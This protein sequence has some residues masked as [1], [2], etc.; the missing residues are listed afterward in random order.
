MGDLKPAILAFAAQ[1]SNQSLYCIA[2]IN[3]MKFASEKDSY[4]ESSNDISD[5]GR[6]IVFYDVEVFPNLF[7]VCYKERGPEK[8]VVT[9]YNPTSEQSGTVVR[10]QTCWL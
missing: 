9:L 2:L 10:V 5:N 1:S 8:K 6:P 4:N 7:M 3:D